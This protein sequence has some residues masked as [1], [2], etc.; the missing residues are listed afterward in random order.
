[1]NLLLRY[2]FS[3][4]SGT[5]INFIPI[6]PLDIVVYPGE[7]LNLH[8]FE[9]RYK[10]LIRECLDEQKHFGIPSVQKKRMQDMG[11]LMEVTE[12][13]KEYENGEMDIRT[14]GIKVFKVLE[15]VKDIPDKLY[16]G[17]IVKYP[18]NIMTVD[19]T[20]I[21][22]LV[23]DEVKRFYKLLSVEDKFRLQEEN[24]VSYDIAHVIG[25]SEEQEYEIGRAHV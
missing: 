10:Q 2:D 21:A 18:E 22:R 17:A 25:L 3:V 24:I 1:M 16:S 13:V 20:G 12:L 15:V 8:I 6:F 7:H 4:L 11:T 14:R 19:D 9:P 5:M 23:V